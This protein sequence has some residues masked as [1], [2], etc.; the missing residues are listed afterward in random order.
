MAALQSRARSLVMTS[1][2]K[3]SLMKRVF[4]VA[5]GFVLMAVT[6]VLVLPTAL[7][8]YEGGF[9]YREVL[10]ETSADSSLR[11]VVAKRVAFPAYDWISPS[12]VIRAELS[13]PA[14]QETVA[15]SRAILMEDGDF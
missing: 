14:T 6:L 12:L 15:S 13:D 3:L 4:F 7:I 5:V 2:L 9:K 11:V 10:S 1:T 8:A